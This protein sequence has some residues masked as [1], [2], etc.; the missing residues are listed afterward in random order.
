MRV[1]E[2][3]QNGG[4]PGEQ[5]VSL[6]LREAKKLHR[7]AISESLAD[8]LPILRRLLGAQVIRD[9]TLPELSRQRHMVQRKHVL[10]ALAIE[11][12]YS[13]W[14]AYRGALIGMGPDTLQPFDVLRRTAGYPNLWF[15]SVEA[16][17]SYAVEHGGHAV[18]VGQ[19]AV[20]LMETQSPS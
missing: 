13:G 1:D 16:A 2:S 10:R 6:L 5:V 8:S 20:I 12:G 4:K 14:E 7:A 19:Q 11:A 15:S 17:E 18:R 9:M 3:L